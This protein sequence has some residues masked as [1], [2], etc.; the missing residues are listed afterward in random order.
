M[1]ATIAPTAPQP[2]NNRTRLR[3]RTS[4]GTAPQSKLL[5]SGR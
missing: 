5:L 3:D 4:K 1:V 2:N